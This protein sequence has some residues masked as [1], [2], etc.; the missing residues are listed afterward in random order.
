MAIISIPILG[1]ASGRFADAEFLTLGG[2]NILRSKKLKRYKPANVT[3]LYFQQ[4]L[5]QIV[6][7]ALPLNPFLVNSYKSRSKFLNWH[8]Q[9]IRDNYPLF[10][11]TGVKTLVCSDITK[12]SFSHPSFRISGI[13]N[14]LS[15]SSTHL[16]FECNLASEF[17]LGYHEFYLV[18]CVDNFRFSQMQLASFELLPTPNFTYFYPSPPFHSLNYHAFFVLRDTRFN[19]FSNSL[20]LFNFSH[21]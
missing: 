14:I 19:T 2:R 16:S 3:N 10:S 8:N 18:L 17:L 5:K 4:L 7:N 13:A 6:V 12:L 20:Y 15:Y 11:I 21:G 9:F 1:R